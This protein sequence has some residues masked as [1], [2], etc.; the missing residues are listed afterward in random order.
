MKAN[1]LRIGNWVTNF[2]GNNVQLLLVDDE[3]ATNFNPIPLTEEWLVKFGYMKLH[4]NR[5]AHKDIP[6]MVRIV[7]FRDEDSFDVM[8]DEHCIT[9][10][11]YVHE[12]QNVIHA[13][14]KT[15]LTRLDKEN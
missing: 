13:I 12:L 14:Y 3:H 9:S 1:E 15:E 4:S 7:S 8:D 6:S 5:Y 2:F 10:V 11:D